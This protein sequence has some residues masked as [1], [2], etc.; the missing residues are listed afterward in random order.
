MQ[1]WGLGK[2]GWLEQQLY[3]KSSGVDYMWLQLV[4]ACLR[5]VS[6]RHV[7]CETLWSIVIVLVKY[8]YE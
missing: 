7:L 4:L 5:G 8:L 3:P 1:G 2:R 6:P